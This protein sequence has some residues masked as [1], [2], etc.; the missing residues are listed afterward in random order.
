MTTKQIW[1]Y[2]TPPT[3]TVLIAMPKGSKVIHV[4]VQKPPFVSFWAEVNPAAGLT[5]YKFHVRGTGHPFTG[6]EDLYIGTCID[7]ELGLVWHVYHGK[8]L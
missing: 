3:D 4:D 7:R 8:W 2:D 5:D 6:E 1:K